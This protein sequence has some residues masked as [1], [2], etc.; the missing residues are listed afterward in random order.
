MVP[1]VTVA[2]MRE[3]DRLMTDEMAISLLQ[4]MENAGRALAQ[5]ARSMFGGDSRGRRVAVLAGPG[6]NGGGGLA[7]AR[8]LSTWGADVFAILAQP[9]AQMAEVPR[10]QLA[11]LER[12]GVPRL[13]AEHL[14]TIGLDLQRADLILDA[15]IGYSLRGAPRGPIAALIRAAN[16]SGIP[17]LA[18]DVPSGL[19]SDTGEA[20]EPTIRASATLTLALPKVGLLRPGVDAWVGELALADISVPEVVYQRLGL[21]VGPI[22]ARSDIVPVR[23]SF[24]APDGVAH[25]TP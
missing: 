21:S 25:V 11:A 23:R 3:V 9:P 2:Q 19:D 13:G 22:F 20:A 6:G 5:Q 12:M 8:R 14:D 18:L 15:L 10:H 1:S 7:A 4:M 16:A 24:E 17:I